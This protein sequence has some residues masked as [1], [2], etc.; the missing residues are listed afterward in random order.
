VETQITVRVKASLGRRLARMAKERGVRRSDIVREALH[1]YLEGPA[2]P[3]L[4][5]PYERVADLIG[6]VR[7]GPSD[8]GARHREH[9]KK[10]FR[11][12]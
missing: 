8:L 12:R 11:A 1:A 3:G 4:G 5:G 9:L 2:S 6:S 7:G 10:A